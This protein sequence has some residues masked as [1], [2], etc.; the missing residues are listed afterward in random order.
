M[1]LVYFAP[2][3]IKMGMLEEI[4]QWWGILYFCMNCK[5]IS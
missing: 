4:L 1:L 2:M 5:S 3:D